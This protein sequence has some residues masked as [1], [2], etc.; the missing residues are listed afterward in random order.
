[1]LTQRRAVAPRRER[2]APVRPARSAGIRRT[3]LTNGERVRCLRFGAGARREE[4][5]NPCWI[6]TDEQRGPSVKDPQRSGRSSG[7]LL[8]ALLLSHRTRGYAPSLRLA[9]N[10]P[11]L[12]APIL[13][14]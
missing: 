2:R 4:E 14:L 10:P 3:H 9:S 13:H 1:M 6:W 11:E 12:G 7:R 5:A 8:A